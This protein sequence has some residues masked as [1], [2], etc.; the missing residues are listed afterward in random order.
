MEYLTQK[1]V[2]PIREEPL[3]F[4][5]QHKCVK[6]LQGKSYVTFIMHVTFGI[7]HCHQRPQRKTRAL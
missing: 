3:N 5:V 7:L 6:P 4:I 1:G 2:L